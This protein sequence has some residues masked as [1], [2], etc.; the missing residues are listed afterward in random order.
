V[1][2]SVTRRTREIGVRVALGAHP[3]DVLWLVCGRTMLLAGV[4]IGAGVALALA[5]GSAF[6]SIVYGVS[7]RDPWAYGA[8]VLTM[9][10]ASALAA[11]WP[12]RRAVRLDPIR[13]LRDS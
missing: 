3:R 7:P 2:Y 11:A 12:A 8:A 9:S 1:S 13:A 5:C 4:G 6:S 10:A